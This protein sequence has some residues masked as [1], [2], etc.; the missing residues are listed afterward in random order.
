MKQFAF[1]L[2]FLFSISASATGG[3]ENQSVNLTCRVDTECRYSEKCDLGRCV[4]KDSCTFDNDC[5]YGNICQYGRCTR[6]EC[7]G[8]TWD[9]R[10]GERC[11]RNRCERDPFAKSCYRHED[12]STYQRCD[13]GYCR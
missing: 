1:I 10:S 11:E 8:G 12:C 5:M 13:M 3:L 7:S 4:D 2:M 9:C 6:G